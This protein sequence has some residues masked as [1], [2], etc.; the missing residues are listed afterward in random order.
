MERGR[1]E[2]LSKFFQYPLLSQ[3]RI[4]LQLQILY[5]KKHFTNFGKSSRGRLRGLSKLF[6]V[7]EVRFSLKRP[8]VKCHYQLL[9]TENYTLKF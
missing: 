7:P 4:K 1:I 2:G 9:N 5:E 8:V 6:R 3:E